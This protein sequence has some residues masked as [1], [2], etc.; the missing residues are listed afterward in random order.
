MNNPKRNWYYQTNEWNP[1]IVK[2]NTLYNASS[3]GI[4]FRGKTYTIQY[5][6]VHHVGLMSHDVADIYTSG[7]SIAGS[8]VCY[9]WIHNCHPEIENGKNI[10]LGIR[11]DDQ[12]R[13][14]S[15]HQNVV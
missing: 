7:S 11:A 10:G 5:N 3:V 15:V 1:S 14:M 9:N 12:C 8:I 13:K 2:G 4:G 6:Y